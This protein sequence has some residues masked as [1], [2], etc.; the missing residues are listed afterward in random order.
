MSREASLS[1]AEVFSL[2][3][4]YLD[5]SLPDDRLVPFLEHVCSCPDC[6]EE[7]ETMFLVDR[8]VRYLDEDNDSELNLSPMLEADMQRRLNAHH[9]RHRSRRIILALLLF[10]VLCFVLVVLDAFGVL[11]VL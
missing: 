2:I 3:P 11:E 7:L 1:H 8:T 10:A 9:A 6:Y 4:Q 5:G